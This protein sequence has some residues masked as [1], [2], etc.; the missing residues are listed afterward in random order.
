MFGYTL[1]GLLVVSTHKNQMF[2]FPIFQQFI[3]P[4][5]EVLYFIFPPVCGEIP[6]VNHNV[7]LRHRMWHV[8]MEI[9]SVGNT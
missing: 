5:N 3:C 2:E 7:S 1:H 8:I 9:V 6:S 4:I